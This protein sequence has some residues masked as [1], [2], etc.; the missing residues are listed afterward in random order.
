DPSFTASYIYLGYVYELIKSWDKALEQYSRILQIDSNHAEA[1]KRRSS[2]RRK[3]G[4]I[5][6]TIYDLEKAA[7]IFLMQGDVDEYKLLLQYIKDI[8]T[9]YS[10]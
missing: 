10:G 7:N 1:Y 5:Q 6:G 9:Q 8:K 3:I 4:D 2:L